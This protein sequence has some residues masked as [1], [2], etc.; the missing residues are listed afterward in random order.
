MSDESEKKKPIP[1]PD[2]PKPNVPKPNIPKPDI[3]K[4]NI[5]N[6]TPS[7]PPVTSVDTD[8]PA[9]TP[10]T[11]SPTPEVVTGESTTPAVEEEVAH[12]SGETDSDEIPK[13]EPGA[14]ETD[15]MKRFLG[16]L[17]DF[18]IAWVI[19]AIVSGVA[20]S[21]VL[22]WLIAGLILL[23]RD[24]LP[25]LDGQSIGKKVMNTKAVKEDGSS[26]SGDWTTGA[27]RNILLAIP[28]A[29]LVECFVI[30]TRSGNPDAGKRLG[31][32]WAKTKVIS[33]D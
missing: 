24:S 28:I 5:E 30:L 7:A 10:S 11:P 17:I 2:I 23:T 9:P 19:A 31:D 15:L 32:D 21:E 14:V 13:K 4:P 8:A 6:T 12:T 27:T 1:K 20:D 25:M 3:P 16:V 18:I 26:L 33:C 29:P 22:R